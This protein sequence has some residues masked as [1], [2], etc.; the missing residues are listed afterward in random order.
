MRCQMQESRF[1]LERDGVA[2]K[3]RTG[4]EEQVRDHVA[5]EGL[6]DLVKKIDP[7]QRIIQLVE[8]D[9]GGDSTRERKSC[10]STT[11]TSRSMD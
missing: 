7:S 2:F 10:T 4:T 9:H 5:D 11:P 8:R 3:S 1:A 6:K